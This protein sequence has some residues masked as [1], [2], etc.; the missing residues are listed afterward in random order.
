MKG[1]MADKVVVAI[2]KYGDQQRMLLFVVVMKIAL[3]CIEAA[4]VAW[5]DQLQ[6]HPLDGVVND[7]QI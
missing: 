6:Y 4:V 1:I 7:D 5:K 2:E 3:A